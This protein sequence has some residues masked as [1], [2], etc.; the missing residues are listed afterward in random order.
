MVPIAIQQVQTNEL[1]NRHPAYN[2]PVKR[3]EPIG[4][5]CRLYAIVDAKRHQDHPEYCEH[6]EK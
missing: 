4:H 2:S 5:H 6:H 1:E 3:V